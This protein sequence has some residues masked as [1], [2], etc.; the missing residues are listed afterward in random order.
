MK[1]FG[2]K[3]IQH[4]EDKFLNK[5]TW[6]EHFTEEMEEIAIN[7]GLLHIFE[8]IFLALDAKSL[9]NCTLVSRSFASFLK[10]PRFWIKKCK[11]NRLIRNSIKDWET[12]F[13]IT[14]E[15]EARRDDLSR[16]LKIAL[17][18]NKKFRWFRNYDPHALYRIWR[19]IKSKPLQLSIICQ[20]FDLADL[21]LKEMYKYS[22]NESVRFISNHFPS[23]GCIDL[24]HSFARKHKRSRIVIKVYLMNYE[25][26]LML[27][28]E[29]DIN[30]LFEHLTF[31]NDLLQPDEIGDTLLH[32][33]AKYGCINV[34]K[35]LA[36]L[37]QNLN[38]QNQ[39]LL[40]PMAMAVK[41]GKVRIVK[42]LLSKN[43]DPNIPDKYGVTPFDYA[44]RNEYNKIVK[45]LEP[46]QMK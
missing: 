31:F 24:F 21:I 27:T 15:N 6:L 45:L 20:E 22:E 44:V 42:F 46:Y 19:K 36:P 29:K 13:K 32:F 26:N 14:E 30:L 38:I 3:R 25:Q 34:M 40:T 16:I 9:L 2:D 23:L 8:K 18:N 11:L 1:K 28:Y 37:T 12:C 35:V 5:V 43:V 10:N 17:L 33:A 4:L 41:K 39:N 7:E